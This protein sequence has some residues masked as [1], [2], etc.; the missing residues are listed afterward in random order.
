MAAFSKRGGSA[1]DEGAA[2]KWNAVTEAAKTA[3]ERFPDVTRY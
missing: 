2:D 1:R 3:M